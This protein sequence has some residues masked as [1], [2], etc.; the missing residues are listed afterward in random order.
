MGLLKKAKE[1]IKKAIKD[2]RNTAEK[3]IDKA[4]QIGA[5]GA[6]IPFVPVM[7][8]FLKSQGVKIGKK[9]PLELAKQCYNIIK[10]KTGKYDDI[11]DESRKLDGKTP[12]KYQAETLDETTISQI[13]NV[14]VSFFTDLVKKKKEGKLEKGSTMDKV[15][16]VAVQID[17]KAVEVATEQTQFQVGKF[18][19]ENIIFI[20][21]AVI[22]V[23]MIFRG[24]KK[25]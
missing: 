14:V 17:S 8:A 20:A 21:L 6:L 25:T 23:V 3:V 19:T 18:L 4:K 1:R 16:N 24:R 9:E 7:L 15:A 12:L 2:V 5:D 11:I 13:V 22:L 10:E